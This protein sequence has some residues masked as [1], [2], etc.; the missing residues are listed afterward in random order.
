MSFV[1]FV[2]EATSPSEAHREEPRADDEDADLR[3]SRNGATAYCSDYGWEDIPFGKG[4]FSTVAW[5]NGGITSLSRMV[6]QAPY[7][8]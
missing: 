2:P 8:P 6:G 4:G 7:V 1:P 5:N 3:H